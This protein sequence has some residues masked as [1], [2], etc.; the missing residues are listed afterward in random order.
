LIPVAIAEAETAPASNP[1][2]GTAPRRRT[3]RRRAAD[4]IEI[5][6]GDG[7]CIRVD[8]NVDTAALRRVLDVVERR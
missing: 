7:R 8:A 5:E 6:L 2:N 4:R 1:L 3:S